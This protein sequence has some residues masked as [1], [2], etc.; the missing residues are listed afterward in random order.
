[1]GL[2]FV[3]ILNIQSSAVSHCARM[4]TKDLIAGLELLCVLRVPPPPARPRR[5]VNILDSFPTHI[6]GG[7]AY[8]QFPEVDAWITMDAHLHFRCA[9]AGLAHK[10]SRVSRETTTQCNTKGNNRRVAAEVVKNKEVE[11]S[12][13]NT[14][15]GV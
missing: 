2:L 3:I 14:N 11:K 8:Y 13:R 1:M 6:P 12:I 4:S 9:A 10:K 15:A 5:V 7:V